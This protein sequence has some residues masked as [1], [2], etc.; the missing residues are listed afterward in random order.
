MI[1][2]TCGLCGLKCHEVES[3]SRNE[4]GIDSKKNMVRIMGLVPPPIDATTL[5]LLLVKRPTLR[6]HGCCS[7]S[8]MSSS[9]NSALVPMMAPALEML[10]VMMT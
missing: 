10:R 3:T 2:G 4:L 9:L 6:H 8:A 1:T 7:M 5:N